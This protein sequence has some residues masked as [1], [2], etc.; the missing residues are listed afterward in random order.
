MGKTV[1]SYRV[2]L[3]HEIQRWN[4]FSRALRQD[5]RIVF[6]QLMDFCKI[7]CKPDHLPISS[8][9]E[10]GGDSKLEGILARI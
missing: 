5:D 10:I 1:P 7:S 8:N 9:N 4:G 3:D 6:E 2:A